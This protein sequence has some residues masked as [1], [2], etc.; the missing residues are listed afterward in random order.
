MVL[1]FLLMKL[2]PL[3][4]LGK[5]LFFPLPFSFVPNPFFSLT[6]RLS[7]DASSAQAGVPF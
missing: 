1:S 4:D 5:S 3:R 6:F 2:R 7:Y